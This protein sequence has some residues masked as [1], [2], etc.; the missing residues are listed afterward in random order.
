MKIFKDGLLRAN[1]KK[2][3][4]VIVAFGLITNIMTLL[5]VTSPDTF[6]SSDGSFLGLVFA[7]DKMFGF[8]FL[9]VGCY[10]MNCS[11]FGF[12]M[13]RNESDFYGVLPYKRKTMFRK[14]MI[15]MYAVISIVLVINLIVL[16]VA[17]LCVKP[18][19]IVVWKGSFKYILAYFIAMILIS[20]VSAFAMACSGNLRTA[21]LMTMLL[22]FGPRILLY[23]VASCGNL[24]NGAMNIMH[25]WRFL[26]PKINLVTSGIM[27]VDEYEI[28]GPD[29]M[30]NVSI[31]GAC[32]YTAVLAGVYYLLGERAYIRRDSEMAGTGGVS[33]ITYFFNKI[34][35]GVLIMLIPICSNVT[36]PDVKNYYGVNLPQIL[37]FVVITIL[38]MLFYDPYIGRRGN[39]FKNLKYSVAGVCVCSLVIIGAILGIKNYER[40]YKLDPNKIE[41]FNMRDRYSYDDSRQRIYAQFEWVKPDKEVAKILA[42]AFEKQRNVVYTKDADGDVVYEDDYFSYRRTADGSASWSSSG[43]YSSVRIKYAGENVTIRLCLDDRDE[44]GKVNDAF[45]LSE[46]YNDAIYYLPEKISSYNGKAIAIVNYGEADIDISPKAYETFRQEYYKLYDEY[47]KNGKLKEFDHINSGIM[48]V[49]ENLVDGYVNDVSVNIT[50]KDYPKTYAYV[51]KQYVEKNYDA[52]RKYLISKGKNVP[53][54]AYTDCNV[55]DNTRVNITYDQLL[56]ILE[57]KDK[58]PKYMYTIAVG[59]N[60]MEKYMYISSPIELKP[61]TD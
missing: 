3:V 18:Q 31:W 6:V 43:C 47:K 8:F 12:L 28:S 36:G 39:R 52:L 46:T 40:N 23:S 38:A 56:K 9:S 49:C 33:K 61:Y 60:N 30:Q 25:F 45:F 20:N 48:V 2:V 4:L 5:T 11:L 1:M 21:F 27:R 16:F 54:K 42:D 10:W 37:I 14:N 24:E 44:C 53:I 59:K 55:S 7:P 58:E 50:Y 15:A 32:A 57:A 35:L 34:F 51:W 17:G 26:S 19:I 29:S 41:G 22:L 13:K